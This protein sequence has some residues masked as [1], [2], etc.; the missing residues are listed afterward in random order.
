MDFTFSEAQLERRRHIRRVLM[1]EVPPELLR[2]QWLSE[3][4]LSGEVWR[5]FVDL[6]L[7][8]ISVPEAFGGAAG[9]DVDWMLAAQEAGYYALPGALL[10]TCWAGA[11][12]LATLPDS[13]LSQ[14][15]LPKIAN[16]AARLAIGY[17]GQALV[18]DAH[19]ADLLLL[20][21]Q[22][23]LHALLPAQ[24]HM[25]RKASLDPSRRLFEIDWRPGPQTCL[26]SGAL[27]GRL[28]EQ[29][30]DRGALAVAAQYS[31]LAM[32]ILD[33]AIDHSTQRKQFGKAIGAFQAVKHYLADLSMAIDFAKPVIFQAAQAIATG[34]RRASAYVSHA[35]LAM[36]DAA[37]LAARH[38]IQVHGAS[39]YTWD[40]DLQ[41]FAKRIWAIDGSCGSSAFHKARLAQHLFA[42]E[43][44]IG[45]RQ[46]FPVAP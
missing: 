20:H 46:T 33:L 15:W 35:R 45:A 2:E 37:R 30:F 11:G 17:P 38:G 28:W 25:T 5:L 44:L 23:E 32:R 19:V 9:N 1:T 42:D 12:L 18:A 13:E 14:H 36:G 24:V 3:E 16:G 10:D 22:G 43:G 39:G 41:I 29:A 21:H 34:D 27:A 31:G 6:G 26:A 8:A 7:T 4:G 40:G